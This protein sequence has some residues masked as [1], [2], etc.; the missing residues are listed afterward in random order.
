[1]IGQLQRLCQKNPCNYRKST[2]KII[3]PY[4]K[5]CM[6]QAFIYKNCQGETESIAT[7]WGG[8]VKFEKFPY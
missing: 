8:D 5:L 6:S 7:I 3:D 4:V 2:C 1:M